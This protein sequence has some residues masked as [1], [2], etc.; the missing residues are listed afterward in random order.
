MVMSHPYMEDY[1]VLP[2]T[3][4]IRIYDR[5][6]D[7]DIS[8]KLSHNDQAI[9]RWDSAT[10][11]NILM[12]KHAWLSAGLIWLPSASDNGTKGALSIVTPNLMNQPSTS[13]S[14]GK[15]DHN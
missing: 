7:H 14:N 6:I 4:T 5:M 2:T 13:S 9:S 8:Y 1:V 11:I 12:E 3:P 15:K 10:W